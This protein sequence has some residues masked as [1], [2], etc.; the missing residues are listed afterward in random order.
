MVAYCDGTVRCHRAGNELPALYVRSDKKRWVLWTPSSYYDC[1]PGGEDHF[2]WNV[3]N[4]P[5]F[6]AGFYPAAALREATAQRK[7]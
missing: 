1:S 2:G 6:A 3:N 4:G 7:P 5:A